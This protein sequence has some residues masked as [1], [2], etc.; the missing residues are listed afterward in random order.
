VNVLSLGAG[1][2]AGLAAEQL[3]TRRLRRPS[4]SV[5]T[6]RPA[7][8]DDVEI[9]TPDGGVI[10]GVQAG[11]GRPLVLLHGITLRAEVWHRQWD[12]VDEFRVIAIDLRGHGRSESGRDGPTIEANARDLA[13]LVDELDLE[14]AVVAGHSMGGMVLGRFVADRLGRVGPD[15]AWADGRIGGLGFI[16]TAGRSPVAR[17]NDTLGRLAPGAQSLAARRP[18]LARRLA[19]IPDNDLGQIMVRSTFG[20]RPDLRDLR[21][22]ADAFEALEVHEFLRAAPSI[23]DHDVL[24]ALRSCHLPAAIIVGSRDS[25]TP[26]VESRR[27]AAAL[28]QATLQVVD[29]AGHQLMLERPDEVNEMLRGLA[30]RSAVNRC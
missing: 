12:L 1:V 17:A 26:V 4:E 13:L 2:I 28:E 15:D 25:L 19:S 20:K 14:G 8:A 23:L 16:S 3:A 30:A 5:A 7:S 22:T 18:R 24:D 9:S 11:S 27:L 21:E 6:P 29:G 10:R